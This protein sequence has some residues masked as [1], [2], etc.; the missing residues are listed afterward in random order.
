VEADALKEHMSRL[1]V[2]QALFVQD[3]LKLSDIVP[4]LLVTWVALNSHD[5]LVW[6]ALSGVPQVVPLALSVW[7]LLL[8]CLSLFRLGKRPFSSSSL[9]AH[10]AI[11]SRS[12][13]AV[14]GQ[15]RLKLWYVC[16]K[17]SPFWKQR[18]TS[19][20]VMLVMVARIS[21]KHQV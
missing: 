3:F 7:L 5:F 20:S 11:M 16:F 8:F 14:V 9:S 1:R 12:S 18:M 15:L 21:K 17:K 19:S 4:R 6:L 2:H 13:T 10:Q